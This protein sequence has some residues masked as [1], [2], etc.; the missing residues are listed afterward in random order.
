MHGPTTDAAATLTKVTDISAFQRLGD[1][2]LLD[3]SKKNWTTWERTFKNRARAVA[4]AWYLNGQIQR[5]GLSAE[6]IVIFDWNDEFAKS[7]LFDAISKTEHAHVVDTKTA[8]EQ[9]ADLKTRHLKIDPVRVAD[10][11][12]GIFT[13]VF[14]PGTSPAEVL[15][16]IRK[17]ARA[18]FDADAMP[19]MADDLAFLGALHAL[20]QNYP[21]IQ[22]RFNTE[23]TAGTI[24]L[25]MI[26]EAISKAARS[27]QAGVAQP[28][29]VTGVV[30][31]QQYVTQASS[32]DAERKAKADAERKAKEDAARQAREETERKAKEEAERTRKEEEKERVHREKE[33]AERKAREEEE[34][35]AREAEEARKAEEAECTRKEEEECTRAEA[36]RKQREEDEAKAAADAKAKT[37]ADAKAKVDADAK[38]KSDADADAAAKAAA[39]AAPAA[40]SAEKE[41]EIDETASA[42][43][44][45]ASASAAD[46]PKLADLK[47][48]TSNEGL[49]KRPGRLDLSNTQKGISGSL[50][51]ALA[52]A[53]II[54]DINQVSYPEGI[55]SPK[56]ELNINAKDGKFRYVHLS[57]PSCSLS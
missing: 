47:I 48:N 35:K 5:D 17:K 2:D 52:T 41:G 15:A 23:T 12:C 21:D 30:G 18:L 44:A 16:M 40:S 13:P 7:I 36:E 51:S 53:R 14:H 32:H 24:K 33:D 28:A 34:R 39:P 42:A 55:M 9:F 37:D 29:D 25:E 3:I 49:R 22:R 6:D 56:I 46:K 19:K 38:V 10:L 57:L 8:A 1:E 20:G 43:P 11:L 27:G 31:G 54:E 26:E 50:P 4:L 45:D